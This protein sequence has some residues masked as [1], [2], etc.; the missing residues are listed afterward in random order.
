MKRVILCFLGIL[1]LTTVPVYAQSE[2]GDA[3]SETLESL[4]HAIQL[5]PEAFGLYLLRSRLYAKT[6]DLEKAQADL[7]EAIR[8]CPYDGELYGEYAERARQQQQWPEALIYVNQAIR[9][10]SEPLLY[11]LMRVEIYSQQGNKQAALND[12]DFVMRAYPNLASAYYQRGIVYSRAGLQVQAIAAHQKA[13]SL[14]AVFPENLYLLATGYLKLGHYARAQHFYA[15]LL[16]VEPHNPMTHI[17]QGIAHFYQRHFDAAE[18]AYSRAIELQK[19][20]PLAYY[21]RGFLHLTQNR[22][23]AA[24]ADLG[25]LLEQA[26][27]H[28][29]GLALRGYLYQQIQQP[30]QAEADFAKACDLGEKRACEH[31][32]KQE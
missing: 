13:Y 24:L 12:L 30:V 2:T 8:L 29:G 22:L 18:A 20:L 6:G 4:S 28:T 27:E 19:N 32:A 10:S 11:Y 9:Y 26:P 25:T 17:G 31:L 5:N 21:Q 1:L 14:Q 15:E 23:D 3:P 16:A 7:E